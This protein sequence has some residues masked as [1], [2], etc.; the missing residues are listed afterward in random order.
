MHSATGH[1]SIPLCNIFSFG[2]NTLHQLSS[3]ISQI[4]LTVFLKFGQLYFSNVVNYI[5]Q[6]LSTIFLKYCQLYFSTMVNCCTYSLAP[7]F[8]INIFKLNDES[9]NLIYGQLNS[10]HLQHC[11][12][13][14]SF[15]SSSSSSWCSHAE[16][17]AARWLSS[18]AGRA[19]PSQPVESQFSATFPQNHS[20]HP[21]LE[22]GHSNFVTSATLHLPRQGGRKVKPMQFRLIRNS[23]DNF[24][25]KPFASTPPAPPTTLIL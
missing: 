13:S 11:A 18:K 1:N 24:S 16:L 7:A 21:R 20:F 6:I 22:P 12:S 8:F 17:I 3:R 25:T 14:S 4:L 2:C 23:L 9:K 15:S 19:I 5:S 10:S